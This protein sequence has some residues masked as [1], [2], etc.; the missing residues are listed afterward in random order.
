VRR[1]LVISLLI[2]AASLFAQGQTVGEKQ[3]RPSKEEQE[4]RQI[5]I[6]RSQ[7][8]KQ[9]D[10][11]TL[12]RIYADDFSGVAASGRVVNKAQLMEIFKANDPRLTFT[13]DEVGVRLFGETAVVTGRLTGKTPDG[14]IIG[15]SRFM[16]VYVKQ[17]GRWQFVAGQ[18]TNIPKQ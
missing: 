16:H 15:S 12:D 7:A 11:K 13:T 18:S 10:M 8:I 3:K 14:E 9:G 17:Q 6:A 4:L 2:I 5:E 1:F